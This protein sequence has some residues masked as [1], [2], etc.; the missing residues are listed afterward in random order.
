MVFHSHARNGGDVL[1]PELEYHLCNFLNHEVHKGREGKHEERAGTAGSDYCDTS[2]FSVCFGA[3]V[4]QP[5]FSP[6]LRGQDNQAQHVPE[7]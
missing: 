3:F 5:G 7:R 2:A 1:A 4:V 6:L